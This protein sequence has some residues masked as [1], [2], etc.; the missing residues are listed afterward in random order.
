M[1]Q[2]VIH[3]STG[4]WI[5]ASAVALAIIAPAAYAT[6]NSIVAIGNSSGTTTAYV[7]RTRQLQTTMI[8]PIS[9][10]HFFGSV[11]SNCGAVY[12]PPA[13][14]AIVVTQVTYLLGTGTQGIQSAV[15]LTDAGCNVSYDDGATSHALET[16]SH[17]FPTGLPMQGVGLDV[18]DS[19][20][21][22]IVVGT[23]YLI[24]STLLPPESSPSLALLKRMRDRR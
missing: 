8:A 22:V 13:G 15:T 1:R 18:S 14:K 4:A 12:T 16:Q 10:V 9:V 11:V 20:A 24:P 19:Y 7:T 2:P 5:F 17:T 23:G 3:M 6:A 21:N